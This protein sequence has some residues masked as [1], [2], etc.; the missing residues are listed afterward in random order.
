MTTLSLLLLLNLHQTLNINKALN[1]SLWSVVTEGKRS[2]FL[3]PSSVCVCLE[4]WM[5]CGVLAQTEETS[6]NLCYCSSKWLKKKLPFFSVWFNGI[7]HFFDIPNIVLFPLEKYKLS[8]FLWYFL[9]Q[10]VHTTMDENLLSVAT[11]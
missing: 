6:Q 4:I 8:H 10:S 7:L 1:W 2:A 11:F 5:Q 9:F 3:S